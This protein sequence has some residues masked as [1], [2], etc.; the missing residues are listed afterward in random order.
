VS[1]TSLPEPLATGRSAISF[2]DALA[3]AVQ[4][5]VNPPD[6][7]LLV[8]RGVRLRSASPTEIAEHIATIR[9]PADLGWGP[10]LF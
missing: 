1:E 5:I 6:N 8:I 2:E 10:D 3:K 7:D 9:N 4:K